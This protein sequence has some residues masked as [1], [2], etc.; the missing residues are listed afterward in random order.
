MNFL[1]VNRYLVPM[2]L[3]IFSYRKYPGW[4]KV[5][6]IRKVE[7]IAA[8]GIEAKNEP[9]R[10]EKAFK[11]VPKEVWHVFSDPAECNKL[12]QDVVSKSS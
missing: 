1:S 10:F 4:I 5:I 3:T 8:I 6:L 11:D 12:V 2:M 9:E 7:D